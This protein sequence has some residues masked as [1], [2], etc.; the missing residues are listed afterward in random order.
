MV[1]VV[2]VVGAMPTAQASGACGS[3]SATSAAFISVDSGRDATPISGIE[4]R[5]VWAIT[6]ASSRVSPEFDSTS[7][8]SCGVIMPRSP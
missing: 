2:D 1:R 5:R 6:S 3:A 8:T 4:K 7:A